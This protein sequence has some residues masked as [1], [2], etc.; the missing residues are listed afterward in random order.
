MNAAQVITPTAFLQ[1][2]RQMELLQT[3]VRQQFAQVTKATETL[4][5]VGTA[6]QKTAGM[7]S[8]AHVFLVEQY[9]KSPR[10]KQKKAHAN[11]VQICQAALSR[12][13]DTASTNLQAML[14]QCF[15]IATDLRAALRVLLSEQHM[16]NAPNGAHR[17]A[18]TPQTQRWPLTN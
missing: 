15:C 4:R 17:F 16:A 2:E 14:S 18:A 10:A 3:H 8:R 13:R 5:T 12:M 1:F 7:L 9:E 6:M 11:L